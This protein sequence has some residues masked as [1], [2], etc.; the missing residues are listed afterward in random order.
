MCIYQYKEYFKK[1][2]MKYLFQEVQDM[3]QSV[4]NKKYRKVQTSP[5]KK[6]NR[7]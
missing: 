5:L 3:L 2:I 6:N 1:T 7:D 4:K